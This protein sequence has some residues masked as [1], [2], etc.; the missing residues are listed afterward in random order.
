[1]G[2]Y[3]I[4]NDVIGLLRAHGV[5]K[6]DGTTDPNDTTV[7]TW[8]ENT[9]AEI[10]GILEARGVEVPITSERAINLLRMYVTYPVAVLVWDEKFSTNEYPAGV[11]RWNTAYQDFVRRLEKGQ[12]YLPG[13]VHEGEDDPVFGIVRHPQRDSYFTERYDETEWDE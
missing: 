5:T 4:L 10:E 9:E 8:I 2:Q 1:M 7:N 3:A 6:I 12:I 11:E 13:V